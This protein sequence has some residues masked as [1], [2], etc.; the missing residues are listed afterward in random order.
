MNEDKD[1]ASAADGRFQP[2]DF[3]RARE[4][5]ERNVKWLL[6][7]AEEAAP[8]VIALSLYLQVRMQMTTSPQPERKG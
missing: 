2:A 7:G 4:V 3:N 6:D 8:I 1:K 5:L